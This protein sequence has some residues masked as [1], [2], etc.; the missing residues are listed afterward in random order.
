[1]S[2]S[3]EREARAAGRRVDHFATFDVHLA[4]KLT[5]PR[6]PLAPGPDL[7]C[8]S[9][10]A[11]LSPVSSSSAAMSFLRSS[12]ASSASQSSTS[13]PTVKTVLQE[14]TLVKPPPRPARPE[15]EQ[16]DKYDAILAHFSAADLK[17]PIGEG[18]SAT[19]EGL[20]RGERLWL[21]EDCFLRYLRANNWVLQRTSSSGRIS[22]LW[23]WVL[24]V[25]SGSETSQMPSPSSRALSS[26][27]ARTGSRTTMEARAK[28]AG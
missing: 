21:T 25:P 2:V 19:E 27:G 9:A 8:P 28:E 26:G 7:D 4:L 16:K 22:R 17:L 1:M 6:P 15:G 10:Y 3:P 13:L 23:E 5:R 12:R 14:P 20:R 24:T 18:K 11:P